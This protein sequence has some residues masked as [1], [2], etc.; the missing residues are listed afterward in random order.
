MQG[1]AQTGLS[2]RKLGLGD[3][4]LLLPLTQKFLHEPLYLLEKKNMN[5]V[6]CTPISFRVSQSL[7]RGTMNLGLTL[8]HTIEPAQTAFGY[9][10]IHFVEIPGEKHFSPSLTTIPAIC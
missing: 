6:K 2:C 10:S 4:H 9:K 1:L 3:R 8:T 7:R 5:R